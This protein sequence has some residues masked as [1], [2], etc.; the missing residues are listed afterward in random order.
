[1]KPATI[2]PVVKHRNQL[3]LNKRRFLPVSRLF[4]R[5]ETWDEE[6]AQ[7]LIKEFTDT[8]N[9]PAAISEAVHWA[10]G[11]SRFGQALE[12]LSEDEVDNLLDVLLDVQSSGGELWDQVLTI[13]IKPFMDAWTYDQDRIELIAR[14]SPDSH[15]EQFSSR[16]AQRS[17]W[18]NSYNALVLHA[19]LKYWPLESVRDVKI[20]FS[21]RVVP[22]KGF[23]YDRKITVRVKQTSLCPVPAV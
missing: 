8:I 20:S 22:G 1:M 21:S 4:P 17:Y 15:P 7:G 14:V 12:N 10:T 2:Y 5:Y 18:I 9:G 13:S 3:T 16:T 6:D 11:D 19:V 23:F